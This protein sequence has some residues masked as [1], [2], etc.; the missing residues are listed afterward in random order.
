M[1]PSPA[2]I[3]RTLSAGRLAGLAYVAYRPGPHRVRHV[4]DAQGRVLLLVAVDSDL[5]EALRPQDGADDIATVI[6]VRD[7]PP[8]AAAP[9]L[10]RVWISGWAR[11]LGGAEA[12][13]AA[14]DFAEILPTGDLLDVG[15]GFALYHLD[16]AEVRLQ[17]A[18]AAFDVD[19]YD[20]AEAEPDP[21]HHIERELLVDP[22]GHHGPE[23]TGFVR[24][25]LGELPAG[26][27]G[28]VP[29][30]A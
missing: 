14:L 3:A 9:S 15:R 24:A 20:Y 29:P 2:E 6:D 21:L 19:P 10:G 23:P 13:R 4:V 18:G 25:Q 26:Q 5:A 11:R 8:S 16:V 7:Q 17:R 22:D 30:R 27:Q 1:Q 28:E 12:S